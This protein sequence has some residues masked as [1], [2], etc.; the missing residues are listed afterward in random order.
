[1]KKIL[2]LILCPWPTAVCIKAGA[3]FHQF[4]RPFAGCPSLN[5]H[6]SSASQVRKVFPRKRLVLFA[7]STLPQVFSLRTCVAEVLPFLLHQ[8]ERVLRVEIR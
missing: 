1:M 3:S 7:T 5:N 6:G 8:T 2:K 4:L